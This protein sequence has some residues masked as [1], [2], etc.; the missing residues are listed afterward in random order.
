MRLFSEPDMSDIDKLSWLVA[1]H[2][3]ESGDG[4]GTALLQ[5]RRSRCSRA[6]ARGHRSLVKSLGFDEIGVRQGQTQGDVKDTIVTLGKQ[7]SQRWYVGYE[8]GLN[9]TAGS[10]QLVYRIARRVSVRAQ[11]G[12]TTR[13]TCTGACAGADRAAASSA[14]RGQRPSRTCGCGSA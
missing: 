12:G 1:G 5:R 6:K 8:R 9:A 10:W 7:L 13:S 4:A 11:A 2:A 14:L 3:S